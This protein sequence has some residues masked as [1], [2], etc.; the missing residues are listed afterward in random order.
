MADMFSNA[1]I[2]SG[3]S[4]GMPQLLAT[5]GLVAPTGLPGLLLSLAALVLLA[6]AAYRRALPKPLPGIPYNPAAARRLL[7]DLPELY[8]ASRT[9]DV[10]GWFSALPARLG[11]PIVQILGRKP[12]V[13]IADFATTQAILLRQSREFD[14]PHNMLASLRGVIPHHHI[15]M[16]TAD[17]Q[18]RRN[19]ELV[20]DLMTPGFLHSVNAPEIWRG[21]GAFVELWRAKARVAGGR[22]F[23]A[24]G[25]VNRVTFDIIKNVAIGKGDTTLVGVYLEQIQAE[26][27]AEHG[28]ATT[29][30]PTTTSADADADKDTPFVFPTPPYDETLEAQYRMNKALTPSVPLPPALFHAINN[31]RPYMRE[32]YASKQRMLTRQIDAAVKRMEAGE[33]LESALDY[34]IQRELGAAKKAERAPVFD[35]P[36]MLD[37]CKCDNL[38]DP[39]I[40]IYIHTCIHPL[41]LEALW[42]RRAAG[43]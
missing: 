29:T 18:F 15:A 17:P 20:R 3:A 21:A 13:V 39:Y 1:T 11:S 5:A 35:S 31:Q 16:R 14:R 40:Y 7:G 42:R 4:A 6:Y 28:V 26:H 22:P 8:A 43:R 30:T 2:P 23:E 37:E 38:P 41:L 9:R 34:M 10:R 33:P 32:A 24:A 36:Y 19:R 27:G 25:D 12:T